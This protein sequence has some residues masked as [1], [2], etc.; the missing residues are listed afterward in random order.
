MTSW[1]RSFHQRQCVPETLASGTVIENPGQLNRLSLTLAQMPS[2]QP[3]TVKP[4]RP[5]SP[6]R[7]PLSEIESDADVGAVSVALVASGSDRVRSVMLPF[8]P[9]DAGRAAVE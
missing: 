6:E 7:P 3:T 1:S 5:D 8:R 2:K 9:A 4:M